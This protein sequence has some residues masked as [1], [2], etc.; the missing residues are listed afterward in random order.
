MAPADL[1]DDLT[2]DVLAVRRLLGRSLP[3]G[4]RAALQRVAAQLSVLVAMTLGRLGEFA[5]TRRW[6]R[7]AATAADRSGDSELAAWVC[8]RQVI[9]GIYEGRTGDEVVAMADRM[10]TRAPQAAGA[11]AMEALSGKARALARQGNPSATVVARQAADAFEE[12]PATVTADRSSTYG[13]AEE[14]LRD[15]E[16]YVYTYLGD[17]RAPQA[18]QVALALYPRE[19]HTAHAQIKLHRAGWL[20]RTGDPGEGL[21]YAAQVVSALPPA[22]RHNR[23]MAIARDVPAPFRPAPRRHPRPPSTASCSH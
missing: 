3:A 21:P 8:G 6:W 14:R 11:G 15:T 13:W 4:D 18:Q 9:R 22:H 1:L 20:V 19:H 16:N 5:R 10:V 2:V 23:V 7:T 17:A 12:L